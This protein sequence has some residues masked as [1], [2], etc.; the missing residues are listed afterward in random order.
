MVPSR[1]LI[2]SA[3]ALCTRAGCRA[4]DFQIG[5]GQHSAELYN[6]SIVS[7]WRFLHMSFAYL[8]LKPKK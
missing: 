8:E 7:V 5:R 6:K 3:I 2:V 1:Q 4:G